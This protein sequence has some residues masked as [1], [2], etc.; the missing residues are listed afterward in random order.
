MILVNEIIISIVIKY[1]N[2]RN[3]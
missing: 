1:L 2:T 3:T